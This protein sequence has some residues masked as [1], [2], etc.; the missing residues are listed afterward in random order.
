MLFDK[1]FNIKIAD[2]G[3]S[4]IYTHGNLLSTP[5]GS[6]CYAAPEMI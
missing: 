3:L 5:C 1:D 6:P 2:F 4:N